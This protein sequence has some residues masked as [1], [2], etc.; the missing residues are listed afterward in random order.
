[1]SFTIKQKKKK[2]QNVMHLLQAEGSLSLE[3]ISNIY[4]IPNSRT[5]AP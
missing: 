2:K 5:I 3:P 1:M 4:I